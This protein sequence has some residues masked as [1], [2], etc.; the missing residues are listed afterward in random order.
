M[1][2][3]GTVSTSAVVIETFAG[4]IN[5][6]TFRF[7]GENRIILNLQELCALHA[8]YYQNEKLVI[9]E[10]TDATGSDIINGIKIPVYQKSDP[11]RQ[12]LV[13]A[14]RTAQTNITVE[15]V[16]LTAYWDTMEK[17]RKAIHAVRVAHTSAGSAGL[18]TLGF[19]IVPQGKMIG[20]IISE[21]NG[22]D[23]TNIDT[24]VQR[25]NLLIEG[26]AAFH[27]NDMADAVPLAYYDYV[28]PAAIGDLLRPFRAYDFRNAGI[29]V[30]SKQVTIQLDV[31]DVSDALVIIPIIEVE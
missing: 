19:R 3:R 8:F 29:D 2:V 31:Q 6:F 22:F 1:G 15:T 5:P 17:D 12:F 9:A 18:E 26:A 25:V 7:G 28:G 16:A 27:L 24:S 20:L 10:N 4:L 13:Q 30:K 11:T 23:D 14:D 21:P